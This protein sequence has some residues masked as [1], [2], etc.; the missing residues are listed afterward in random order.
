[1]NAAGELLTLCVEDPKKVFASSCLL[2]RGEVSLMRHAAS[3]VCGPSSIERSFK[4][5]IQHSS[6]RRIPKRRA[7]GSILIFAI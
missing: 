7:Y 1:M 3:E 4:C 5:S 2:R 6:L